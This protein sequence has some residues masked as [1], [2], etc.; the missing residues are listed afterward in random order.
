MVTG[1]PVVLDGPTGWIG[2][3]CEDEAMAIWLMRAI[4]VENIMVRREG[5]VL[6]LP[7]GCRF[8]LEGEIKNVVTVVAKTYHYWKEHQAT[9]GA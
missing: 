4:V 7:V 1:L 5:A 9:R 3:R 8:T 6:Y 2:L